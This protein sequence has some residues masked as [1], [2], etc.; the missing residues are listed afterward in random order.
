MGILH[1]YLKYPE[2]KVLKKSQW[3]P[4]KLKRGILN[5]RAK[6]LCKIFF[7]TSVLAKKIWMIPKKH[8]NLWQLIHG[9][10]QRIPGSTIPICSDTVHNESINWFRNSVLSLRWWECI[11]FFLAMQRV[12]KHNSSKR[13]W[14][15]SVM[16][17]VSHARVKPDGCEPLSL[18]WPFCRPF[19]H[20]HWCNCILSQDK[21]LSLIRWNK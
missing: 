19:C 2:C 3:A 18:Q 15:K 1:V 7:D 10:K 20:H 6:W 13:K 14:K 12:R 9:I 8:L 5:S 16:V 17:V 4:L 21:W 11:S